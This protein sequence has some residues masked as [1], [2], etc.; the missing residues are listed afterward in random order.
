MREDSLAQ[1]Q[2]DMRSGYLWGAPGIAASSLAW[3]AAASVA[4]TRS[5]GEAVWT[6]LVAGALIHPVGVLLAKLLGS[7]GRHQRGNPL[8]KLALEGTLW[9]LAGIAIAF[10]LATLR[11]EWF[12]PA[13][14]LVIGGRYLT[15]QSIYGLSIYWVLGAALCAAGLVS[16]WLGVPAHLSALAGSIIELAFA[17]I[18]LAQSKRVAV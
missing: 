10:G 1:A 9:M 8:A 4:F 12:F 11:S 16:A 5:V 3:L 14:L 18:V 6:L 17:A 2:A 13:M 15:F 7:P